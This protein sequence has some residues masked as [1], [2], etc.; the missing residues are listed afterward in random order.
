[1]KS[2]VEIFGGSPL[3]WTVLGVILMPFLKDNCIEKEYFGEGGGV[4]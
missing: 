4:C 2:F 1:M 3:N